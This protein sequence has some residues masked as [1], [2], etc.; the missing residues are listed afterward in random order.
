MQNKTL[1]QPLKK[2]AAKAVVH[3]SWSFNLQLYLSARI[4]PMN[5]LKGIIKIGTLC[6]YS[7]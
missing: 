4:K 5:Q 2:E 1:Y 7:P 3:G 6:N